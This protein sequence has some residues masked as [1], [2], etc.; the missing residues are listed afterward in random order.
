VGC[1]S[2]GEK[3]KS[4]P[5]A[6]VERIS[7][8]FFIEGLMVKLGKQYDEV[9]KK[10]HRLGIEVVVEQNF[11]STTTTNKDRIA[12]SQNQ[13]PSTESRRIELESRSK[14]SSGVKRS[15]SLVEEDRKF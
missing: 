14:A 3:Q 4:I 15:N 12:F 6:P 9:N 1:I 13:G 11:H 10:I 5:K 8:T 2:R 7:R